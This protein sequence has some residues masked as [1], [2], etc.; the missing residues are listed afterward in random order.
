MW[1]IFTKITPYLLASTLAP[2]TPTD[3]TNSFLQLYRDLER[4]GPISRHVSPTLRFS[5][6]TPPIDGVN[7]TWRTVKEDDLDPSLRPDASKPLAIY[8]PGLD[9]YGIS[10]APHQFDDLA[11]AFELWRLTVLPEDMSSFLQMVE[12]VT[13]FVEQMSRDRQ[14]VLIGESC[15]GLFASAVALR[16]KRSDSLKGLVLVNPATSFDR[17]PWATLVPL[18]TSWL[19]TRGGNKPDKGLS[20]YAVIGSLILSALVPDNGQR[21][22]IFNTIRNLPSLRNPT[23]VQIRSVLNATADAFRANEER[24][25]PRILEHRVIKWLLPG[26]AAVNSCLSQIETPTLVVAGGK[27]CLMPSLQEAN[28]LAAL[29]PN[30]EKLIVPDRGHFVLDDT[31]NL[32][33]AILYSHIDALDWKA[34]KKTYDPIRDYKLPSDKELAVAIEKTVVPSRT[35][36]SPVFFSTD[37]KGKR[38]RGLSKIPRP[39]GSL[40]FVSNHQFGE[41]QTCD[42]RC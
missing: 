33:E 26:T 20:A 34:T 11:K 15:G 12:S 28:R 24:L 29:L 7:S 9:G 13:G 16:L 31:V 23:P 18:L 1:S 3:L 41:L 27:D 22:R 5:Y 2:Q 10:A 32:T 8:L 40:L 30:A 38:W 35:A 39:E 17:T 21:G 14:V 42:L 4:P 25:P 36:H 19:D 37:D 6:V